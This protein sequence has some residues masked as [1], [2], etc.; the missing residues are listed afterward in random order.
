MTFEII[1]VGTELLL[2]SI[3]NTNAQ[4]LSRALS[5]LGFDVYYTT[6][7]GD[8]SGRLRAALEA[9]SKRADAVI[10]TGGLGP[11][12]DDLTKETIAEFCNLR[13]VMDEKSLSR[14]EERFSSGH[15]YMPKSNMKQAEL[16]EGCIILENDN[17]TAP[18]A[19]VESGGKIFI[20]LPGPPSEMKP[21]FESKVKP[22]LRKFSSGVIRSKTVKVFGLGESA[23]DEML[24][25]LIKSSKNPSVAPY[26]KPGQV[27][28]RITAK[29]DTDDKARAMIE[30][31]Y[32]KICEILGDKVYGTGIDNSLEKTAVEA[33]I[34][35]GLS[36]TCAESC[37]G[38][39]VAQKITSVPGASECFLGGVVTYSNSEKM[40]LLGVRAETL[41]RYGAVSEQTALEMSAGARAAAGADIAVSTTGIA[42]PGGGTDEKPVGLVYVSVCSESCHK[43]IKL[44]LTGGRDAVRERASLHA[45]DLIRREA[46]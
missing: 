11:T 31:V 2:G 28:L 43:A 21:M 38:G 6:A 18:G 15:M 9:A 36:V 22:Y 19:V 10:T 24:G 8:N 37:T 29:A 40:R 3:L 12:E 25:D 41:E 34:K 32:K 4:Y 44:N 5:E 33:L 14:I 42:G 13:C 23:V 26:A 30:P 16:P 39:M 45:L 35:R 17:G 27:E 1:S 20:M 46:T 7:V